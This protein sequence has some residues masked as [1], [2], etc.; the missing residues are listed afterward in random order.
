MDQNVPGND[1]LVDF[2]KLWS[3]AIDQFQLGEHSIHGPNHWRKVEINGLDLANYVEADKTVIRL[4]AL[5]HDCQRFSDGSDPQHGERAA[6]LALELQGNL[7]QVTEI[8]LESLVD[9][10]RFHHHGLTSVDST[11]GC[12]WDADRLELTRVGMRP[13][14]QFMSTEEGK[15]RA[16]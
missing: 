8:Q 9:A 16:K 4:F 6:E 12:C 10:C 14:R 11:I 5:L 7:F 3:F 2:D 15:K 1:F 13:A